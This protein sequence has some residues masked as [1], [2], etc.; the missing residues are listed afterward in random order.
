MVRSAKDI[1]DLTKVTPSFIP[2]LR[3]NNN[4]SFCMYTA[5]PTRNEQLNFDDAKDFV[6]SVNWDY[7]VG[8]GLYG[9]EVSI[10]MN[11]YQKFY[12]LLPNDLPKF[13]ITNGTWSQS[14]QDT[15]KFLQWCANKF[16]VYISSCTKEHKANQNSA[17]IETLSKMDGIYVKFDEEELHP[18]GRYYNNTYKCTQ[19]CLWH[20]Q[21]VRIG[22]FPTGDVLLQNC[23]GAYPIVGNIR[24]GFDFVFDKAVQVRRKGNSLCNKL[25]SINDLDKEKH[26]NICN[27][28]L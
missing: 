28:I 19:K 1:K 25:K 4:C 24:D 27:K 21:P 20:Q 2:S 16:R 14:A 5:G 3:C 17:V 8:W 15:I 6:E 11:L 10:E 26:G 9:G 12:E 23:D 18:M 13:I 22:I 7:V